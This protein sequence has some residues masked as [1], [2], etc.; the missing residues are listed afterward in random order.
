[1]F[2][3]SLLC[4][5]LAAAGVLANTS[6]FED[7]TSQSALQFNH[8]NGAF[9][10]KYLPETMGSGVAFLDFNNDGLQ[11][12]LFVNGKNWTGREQRLTTSKLFRNDGNRKF[13]DVT[14]GSGLGVPLYGMGVAAA[15]YDNDGDM[16]AYITALD[17]DRLFQ[18]DGRGVFKDVTRSAGINNDNFGTSAAWL[19]YDKDGHLDL[20]V[21]NYVQWSM[22]SDIACTLDGKTKS[23]CTPESYKGTASKLYRNKKDGTFAD[24]TVAAGL[25]DASSKSLG[26]AV[27][28][29]N[30]DGWP[31]LAVANDTQP[32]KLYRNLGNGKFAEEGVRSGVAYSED[33]VA[34]GGMGIDWADFDGSNRP[35]IAIGNFAGQMLG[36]YHNEGN[37]LF[38]DQAPRSS[39]G[40]A[41]LLSLTF[42]V[43]FFDYDLDG[44]SDL[45]IVNGH[46]DDQIETFQPKVKYRQPPQ[47]FRNAGA[48][49][50]EAA[51]QTSGSALNRPIVGRGAAYGDIDNDGA[52]DVIVTTNGGPAYVYRNRYSGTNRALKIRTIG[53]K[54]N[55]DGI[56]ARIRVRTS[57]GLQWQTVKSGSSY[58]SQSELPLTFGLGNAAAVDAIEVQW[59]AGTTDVITGIAADEFITITEGSGITNRKPIKR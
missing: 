44:R 55:R 27:L 50:F 34:R 29:F 1:L 23:Y 33:G 51:A 17:G 28:D 52:L 18:N 8:N 21:A 15:D 47:L 49:K 38:V 42:A 58:C 46:I 35:S 43:L 40:R 45:F 39:V 26:V 59:P 30:M 32:N 36:L 24:V 13:T 53:T 19:D 2:A 10:R 56:G 16:D 6:E 41:T 7:I 5:W 3:L 31:D 37:G 4:A 54:S 48:G 25:H 9:G 57:A 11:D 20:F 14:S 22:T 12:V